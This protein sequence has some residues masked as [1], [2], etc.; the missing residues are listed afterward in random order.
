MPPADP[1]EIAEDPGHDPAPAPGPTADRP[2]RRP[3]RWGRLL[4]ALA[5]TVAAAVWFA[6]G[7]LARTSLRHSVLHRL[8]PGFRG[9]V[10]VGEADLGWLDPVA[11][12][13][14]RVA[15]PGGGEPVFAADEL[16]TARPLHALL[17]AAWGGENPR[18][19]ARSPPSAPP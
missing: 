6:P 14:V 3:V 7:L 17:S 15:A 9:E 13:G 10:T 11:L 19:S 2:D 18:T 1:D 12:R 8:S 16:R 4:A 5:V